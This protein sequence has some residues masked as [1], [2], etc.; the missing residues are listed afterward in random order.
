MAINAHLMDATHAQKFNNLYKKLE[1]IIP[2]EPASLLHGDMWS[3]NF[4]TGPDGYVCLMDPAVYYGHRETE[5]AFSRLFGGF[6]N[7]FYHAYNEKW[8]LSPGFEQRVDIHNL[9]PLLVHVN[10]FGTSYLGGIE[11]TL[12]KYN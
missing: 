12:K 8:P 6:G 9:Y 1:E 2:E 3:G 7:D 4:M 11:R 10:L 5:I